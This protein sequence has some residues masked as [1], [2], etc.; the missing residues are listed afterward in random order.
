MI[1]NGFKTSTKLP[2]KLAAGN[3]V[4]RHE[5]IALHSGSNVNGAQLYPQ[6]TS[7]PLTLFPSILPSLFFPL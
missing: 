5:I 7:F 6:C 4:I 1:K 3:Y 2:S